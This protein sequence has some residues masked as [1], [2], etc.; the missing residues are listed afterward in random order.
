MTCDDRPEPSISTIENYRDY[1]GNDE[2]RKRNYHNKCGLCTS[3]TA[4]EISQT[5]TNFSETGEIPD[6]LG[7]GIPTPARLQAEFTFNT[8]GRPIVKLIGSSQQP[9]QVMVVGGGTGSHIP[10]VYL[11]K[12]GRLRDEADTFNSA[13]PNAGII[14]YE[15]TNTAGGLSNIT[16]T[17]KTCREIYDHSLGYC[18]SFFCNFNPSSCPI[19][20]G[21]EYIFGKP[22]LTGVSNQETCTLVNK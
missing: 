1:I 11:E 2:D 15:E 13:N 22:D 14:S 21:Y 17:D 8:D 12:R 6:T 10:E 18:P 3:K 4:N 19:S 20:D 5:Y 16:F 9:G 7:P